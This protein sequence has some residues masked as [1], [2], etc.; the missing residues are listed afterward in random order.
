VGVVV[1]VVTAVRAG[2]GRFFTLLLLVFDADRSVLL[3][4]VVVLRMTHGLT[5]AV[6]AVAVAPVTLPA[7]AAT[8]M[9]D[10]TLLPFACDCNHRSA[11][12]DHRDAADRSCR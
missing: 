9:D 2:A 11:D 10:A 8:C 4:L 7:G 3:T 12:R 6:A 1:T 5:T